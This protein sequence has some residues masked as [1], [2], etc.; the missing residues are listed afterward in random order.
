[1]HTAIHTLDL[2]RCLL[3]H[4][5]LAPVCPSDKNTTDQTLQVDSF[6]RQPQA[7]SAS[8]RDIASPKHLDV[9][10]CDCSLLS[11]PLFAS[12]VT[13]HNRLD[14]Y[15][16]RVFPCLPAC[17]H[18]AHHVASKSRLDTCH[19]IR[20]I[21]MPDPEQCATQEAASVPLEHHSCTHLKQIR[22]PKHASQVSSPPSLDFNCCLCNNRSS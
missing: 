10:S 3:V 1:M 9:E 21:R 4:H 8:S 20:S 17:D 15:N 5:P 16:V 7:I 13:A 19:T 6:L 22:L 12:E 18:N 2:Y 14:A 11:S